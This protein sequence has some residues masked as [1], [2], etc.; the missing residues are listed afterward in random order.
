MTGQQNQ[1]SARPSGHQSALV[2][3]ASWS[4]R[5]SGIKERSSIRPQRALDRPAS[6]S[7]RPS[8][9]NPRSSDLGIC[10][11]SLDIYCLAFWGLNIQEPGMVINV[12]WE[13]LLGHGSLFSQGLS[14][15][16]YSH[17]SMF[18]P[19]V[20]LTRYN[21]LLSLNLKFDYIPFVI[22][23]KTKLMKRVFHREPLSTWPGRK[24]RVPPRSIVV[25]P[26]KTKL[27]KRVFHREP[28]S[29]WPGRK[30]R[31]PPRSIVIRPIKTKLMKRVFHREPLSTW[32]GRKR[33]VPP[34]S[35]VV[36]PI[37]TKLM[38]KVFHRE[39][40]STWPGR[41]RRV[42]P[43]NNAVQKTQV[44]VEF[45]REPVNLDGRYT[46][47][48]AENQSTWTGGIRKVPSRTSQ[49]GR[50]VY[51]EFHREPMPSAQR[52]PN[53]SDVRY[54]HLA[55]RPPRY[56][57]IRPFYLKYF[58]KSSI[59]HSS[60]QQVGL[61]GRPASTSI[62]QVLSQIWHSPFNRPA[63][64]PPRPS[65]INL[66]RSAVQPQ[67]ALGHPASAKAGA[68]HPTIWPPRSSRH[69]PSGRITQERPPWSSA[70]AERPSI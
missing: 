40:L 29:T 38:K 26:I 4:T 11:R 59:L 6:S 20:Y 8:G 18:N 16:N 45:R 17:P 10:V 22:Q 68:R 50:A 67:Q 51:A 53:C 66:D 64:W 69:R 19:P 7:A 37:K 33:R 34:R 35:I 28:L 61:Q 36:R 44:D 5:P 27:M 21:H 12:Y 70:K 32:S 57:T 60:V 30:R 48:S 2:P 65:D 25:R 62:V 13:V 58:A 23:I 55:V 1:M 46:Q 14:G 39:P 42:P 3:P 56:V 43:R 41:K 54:N 47:S 49:L 31:V 52:S 24:R 9:R 15:N 63:N